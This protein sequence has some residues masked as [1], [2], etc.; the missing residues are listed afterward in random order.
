MDALG[1]ATAVKLSRA[2]W[3]APIAALAGVWASRR[4]PGAFAT[5]G[6]GVRTFRLPIPLFILLFIAAS[7]VRTLFPSLEEVQREFL[8]PI[9]IGGM[10]VALFLIGLGLTRKTL[11]AVGWRAMLLGVVLWV[12]LSVTSLVVVRATIS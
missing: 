8:Q 11:A 3:I 7:G 10:S 1:I 12:I 4:D 5:P 6:R 2:V 9:A